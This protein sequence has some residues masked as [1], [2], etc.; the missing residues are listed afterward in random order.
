[1]SY[2]GSLRQGNPIQHLSV[3]EVVKSE[4]SLR[5][6]VNFCAVFDETVSMDGKSPRK[7]L[8]GDEVQALYAGPSTFSTIMPSHMESAMTHTTARSRTRRLEIDT[9]Q[10]A[11]Q[12]TWHEWVRSW[13]FQLYPVPPAKEVCTKCGRACSSCPKCFRSSIFLHF[14]QTFVTL[15]EAMKLVMKENGSNQFKIS[16]GK[17]SKRMDAGENLKGIHCDR[18]ILEAAISFLPTPHDK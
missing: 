12:L 9:A 3:V 13:V 4:L 1:M 7:D 17:K 11:S 2:S 10:S 5:K 8:R 18:D 15:K 14:N 6:F 16:H